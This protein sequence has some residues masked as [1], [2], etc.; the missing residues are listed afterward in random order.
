M[1]SIRELLN[2]WQTHFLC[3]ITH[4][5]LKQS[6]GALVS[7]YLNPL[8]RCNFLRSDFALH[9]SLLTKTEHN[10]VFQHW[11]PW[12][13]NWASI[14]TQGFVPSTF[15]FF[16]CPIK[17]QIF[18]ELEEKKMYFHSHQD[19]KIGIFVLRAVVSYILGQ[20]VLLPWRKNSVVLCTTEIHNCVHINTYIHKFIEKQAQIA[21]QALEKRRR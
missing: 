9:S 18:Q 7:K 4:F 10:V 2:W 12:E 16:H 5:I 11:L 14:P 15:Q 8:N 17:P 21:N 13:E 20:F 19:L 1:R 6:H 3:T